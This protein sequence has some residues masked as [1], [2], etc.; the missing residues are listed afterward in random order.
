MSAVTGYCP[1]PYVVHHLVHRRCNYYLRKKILRISNLEQSVSRSLSSY[2]SASGIFILESF[3]FLLRLQI[4]LNP[5][6][7]L[8]PFSPIIFS[9]L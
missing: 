9:H 1:T 2:L 7:V 5:I 3:L 8:H 6:I 4:S